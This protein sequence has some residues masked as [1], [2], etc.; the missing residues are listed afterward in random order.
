MLTLKKLAFAPLFL[1]AFSVLI[2]KLPTFL[3]SSDIL[4]SLS[5]STFI[6]L[7]I[8]S[9]LISLSSFLFVVFSTLSQNWKFSLP[10]GILAS[11]IPFIF[12][13]TGM[14]LVFAVAVLVSL[15]LTFLSLENSLK[16]YLTFQPNT[17]LAPSIRHLSQLLILTICL[18][19]FLST[20][21][22]IAQNG[23][24]IPD[25]LIDSALKFTPQLQSEQSEDAAPPLS[26]PKEQLELLKQNPQLL[27]QSGLDPNILD[28]LSQTQ[29]ESKK[30]QGAS[31]LLK[32]TVKDQVQNLIKPYQ[33]FIPA[34]LSILLF[35]TLQSLTSMLRLLVYPLLWFNFYIL[36]QIGFIRFQEEMRP[37]KKMVV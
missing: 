12:L 6:Q 8:L 1:L 24:Q 9:A 35:F 18:V 2:F 23:F 28:T 14:A 34:V 36:E 30:S 37:V 21:K 33:N 7:M 5:V 16:S 22:I 31:D 11:V 27:K 17:L 29:D 3:K 26:I 4:F 20:N 25:S 10:V 15:L 13:E 19:Y 32:Q